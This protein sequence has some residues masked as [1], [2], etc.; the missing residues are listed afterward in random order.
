MKAILNRNYVKSNTFGCCTLPHAICNA[1][2]YFIY[3]KVWLRTILKHKGRIF[4]EFSLKWFLHN[5]HIFRKNHFPY[6]IEIIKDWNIVGN[7]KWTKHRI[8]IEHF[9]IKKELFNEVYKFYGYD[10]QAPEPIK[11]NQE[12]K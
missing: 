3:H 11:I 6:R 2:K 12:I 9:K 4:N 8:L 10:K 7:N 5:V 1:I